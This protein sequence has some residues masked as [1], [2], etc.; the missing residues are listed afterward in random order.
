MSVALLL[1]EASLPMT[2]AK[3]YDVAGTQAISFIH[4]FM[5]AA[6]GDSYCGTHACR[7]TAW[8]HLPFIHI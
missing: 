8:L 6:N 5:S 2:Q 3:S 4:Y 1:D 7:V